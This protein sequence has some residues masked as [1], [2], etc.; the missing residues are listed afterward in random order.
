M[1]R[2]VFI[3][4]LCLLLFLPALQRHMVSADS[5]QD[6]FRQKPDNGF[7]HYKDTQYPFSARYPKD[8]SIV[9]ITDSVTRLM[10]ESQD[11]ID[12]LSINVVG[13]LGLKQ[14]SP[15]ELVAEAMKM[16]YAGFLR[17]K[18]PDVNVLDKGETSISN[19]PA[20]YVIFT[21]TIVRYGIT[22]PTISMIVQTTRDG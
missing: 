15:K 2:H 6:S 20:I 7:A 22:R 8:W 16:D 14:S 17:P 9:P 4:T 10:V 11:G 1:K 21:A 12:S 5:S 18:Y 3:F 13:Q 19:Q